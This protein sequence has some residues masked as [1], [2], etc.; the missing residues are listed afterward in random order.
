MVDGNLAAYENTSPDMHPIPHDVPIALYSG[1][2]EGV[3]REITW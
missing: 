3:G 1:K 2:E